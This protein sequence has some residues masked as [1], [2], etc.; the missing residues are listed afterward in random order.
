MRRATAALLAILP[1]CLA[2]AQPTYEVLD[3]G[4][5]V[6]G[7]GTSAANAMNELGYVV[8]TTRDQAGLDRAFAWNPA[9]GV[10]T[11]LLGFA[12]ST[13]SIAN[14]ANAWA[15]NNGGS[16][17]GESVFTNAGGQYVSMHASRWNSSADRPFDFTAP[18]TVGSVV[19]SINDDGSCAGSQNAANFFP[20]P[21]IWNNAGQPT[22]LGLAASE[23]SGVVL[24]LANDG[25]ALVQTDSA[26]LPYAGAFVRDPDGTRHD[27]G[28]LPGYPRVFAYDRNS[29]GAVVGYCDNVGQFQKPFIWTP[30]SGTRQLPLGNYLYG[31]A[32]SI[33]DSGVIVG[34]VFGTP[35][36][37]LTACIWDNPELPPVLLTSRLAPSSANWGIVAGDTRMSINNSGWIMIP[38]LT[39][40][41]PGRFQHAA[42]MVPTNP[43]PIF[44]DHPDSRSFNRCT[45]RLFIGAA[46]TA[47]QTITYSWTRNGL[48]VSDGQFGITRIRG[49]STGYVIIDNP[50]PDFV[51]G[52]WVCVATN[53]CGSVQ[54]NSANIGFCPVDI[55]CDNFVDFFDFDDFVAC[56]EG[57]PCPG[58]ISPDFNADGFVDFF[59]FDDFV[60]AFE[61]GC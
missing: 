16:I 41:R 38:G 60:V 20:V 25:T 54:S 1:A 4:D 49:S 56:F 33:S 43:C 61:L 55:N 37:R 12:A 44:G 26:A 15:I 35:L 42:V 32:E 2:S 30:G 13:G 24:H 59:D 23:R 14:Y 18:A 27:I 29:S 6:N 40:A 8:G 46:A 34:Y 11:P 21:V 3:C 10:M 31:A 47:R 19:R 57:G 53:P 50:R 36:T 9:T 17:A 45:Q 5:L 52:E 58:G 7:V 28:A 51:A 22:T 39:P 48:P